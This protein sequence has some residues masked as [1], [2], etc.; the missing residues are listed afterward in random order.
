MKADVMEI[1]KAEVV[2]MR[3]ESGDLL[4]VRVPPGTLRTDGR[5]LKDL[6]ET[7]TPNGCALLLLP[8]SHGVSLL[9]REDLDQLRQDLRT[10]LEDL[11]PQ[12]GHF[13]LGSLS[14]SKE[15]TMSYS[16]NKLQ[17]VRS[18]TTIIRNAIVVL[19]HDGY[20]VSALEQ[21]IELLDL[22]WKRND[23]KKKPS[24]PYE[25]NQTNTVKG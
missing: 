11:P 6:L 19:K 21:T 15:T 1:M 16:A 9:K 14:E 23:P 2:K 17:C 10:L 24:S 18:A 20:Q 25:N 8:T 13:I 5:Q 12:M 22:W 4:V 7:A 3:P